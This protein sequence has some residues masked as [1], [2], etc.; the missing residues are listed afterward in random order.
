MYTVSSTNQS[1]ESGHCTG[2]PAM[3]RYEEIQLQF[4][5]V[6]DFSADTYLSE[7]VA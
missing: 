5:L 4:S 6:L 1:I 3:A 2:L 7:D